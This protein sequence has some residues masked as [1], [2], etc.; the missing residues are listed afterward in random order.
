M[1]TMSSGGAGGGGGGGKK[2][3]EEKASVVKCCRLLE[4][5]AK[6]I[7]LDYLISKLHLCTLLLYKAVT[8]KVRFLEGQSFRKNEKKKTKKKKDD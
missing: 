4:G 8:D 5:K 7:I 2:C 3:K 6:K 1:N